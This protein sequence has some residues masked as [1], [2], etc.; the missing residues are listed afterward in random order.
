MN[1]RRRLVIGLTLLLSTTTL[2]A[3]DAAD[4]RIK[5]HPRPSGYAEP[6]E[7]R[8][9]EPQLAFR[10]I[11]KEIDVYT[12]A[13][14]SFPHRLA[15][16]FKVTR[17]AVNGVPLDDFVVRN[18]VVINQHRHVHGSEDFSVGVL[19]DW[20]PGKEYTVLV[21]GVQPDGEP[22]EL[23]VTGK[24]PDEQ[25]LVGG[26]SF[27]RPTPSIPFYHLSIG[28]SK[29]AVEP[30]KVTR[31]EVDG[32]WARDARVFNTGMPDPRKKDQAKGI[33]GESYEGL[34]DGSRGV[35]IIA[36]CNWTA[37][38]KHTVKVTMEN[39]AGEDRSFE[40][41]G[42]AGGGGYWDINWPHSISIV[43]HETAGVLRQGEP[44]HL[45]LGMFA[46][47]VTD[48][49]KGVRVVVYDPNH[50]AADDNGYVVA[51][52]QVLDV[53]E[54]RD[55]EVLAIEEK[56]AE[57]G[58]PVHR[59]DP[60]TTVDL[61]FLA[62]VLPYEHKVYQV[63]Y[64]NPEAAAASVDLGLKVTNREGLAQVV[65][66]AHYRY[67]LAANSGAVETVTVLGDGEPVL[68][69]HKLETNGAVHWNPGCYAPPKP[70]VHASDWENPEFKQITGPILHRTRKYAPLP[71][72]EEV[73]AHVSYEFYAGQPYTISSSLMEVKQDIYV[74]ALR[75]GEIVFNHAVLNEFVWLDELG[76]VRSAMVKSLKKH[77]I[78]GME[79][80]AGTPWFALIN[81]EQ[82]VGFAN[83]TLA[84]ENTNI[85]GDPVS[86]AQP[87]LY[88]Q[89]RPWG[90]W[91]RALVYPF[92]GINLT[93]LMRVRKGS[94]YYEKNAYVPFRLGDDN[95]P[96]AFVDNVRKQLTHPLHVHEF[97]LTNPRTPE[98]WIMPI[99]TAPF[100]EG[101]EGAVSSQK[102]KKE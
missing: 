19:A 62:D 1:A 21:A 70:W 100:D 16:K 38:S 28:L 96:F 83:I 20:K 6:G 60:T 76:K 45:S 42:T 99:L 29:E 91:S 75:N 71:H 18:D 48:P 11:I 98:K 79:I 84:Y 3:D 81:R 24:A 69:E 95:A 44:V 4:A 35:Q 68:L 56:D 82:K 102:E 12:D 74:K 50:P 54:W 67:E 86:L 57:T 92:G 88:V 78:H 90:Y 61:V 53:V 22:V 58:E 2:F 97:Q 27:G 41:E 5:R 7:A 13:T 77:P 32:Q 52:H 55:E 8:L 64:G 33:S 65:E 80:P 25:R 9:A 49:H 26:M 85:Y 14:A 15:E 72:M 43:V 66:N 40:R 30:G 47:D 93:R 94:L 31:V 36:P 51:P 34:I 17:V 39:D 89:N 37:W 46:D 87:Y 10:S 101:V 59:Y 73:T 63:L 23:E